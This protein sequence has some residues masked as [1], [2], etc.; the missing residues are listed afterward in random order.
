[1]KCVQKII[2]KEPKEVIIKRVSNEQAEKLVSEGWAFASKKDWKA[3]PNTTWVK[4]TTTPNAIKEAKQRRTEK[5]K[6]PTPPRETGSRR[7]KAT[8]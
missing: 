4:S 3:A 6:T 7:S 5:R 1:M 2:N 8:K